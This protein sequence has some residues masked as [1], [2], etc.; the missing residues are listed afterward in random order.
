MLGPG[1][2]QTDLEFLIEDQSPI[3][4]LYYLFYKGVNP[5]RWAERE[6]G[7]GILMVTRFENIYCRKLTTQNED[8]HPGAPTDE[9]GDIN[10][11]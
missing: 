9:I 7:G 11:N 2:Q 5:Q 8:T 6:R 1:R 3:R 4:G 10:D